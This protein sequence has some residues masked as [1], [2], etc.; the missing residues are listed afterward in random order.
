ML[1]KKQRERSWETSWETLV[2][3]GASWATF[4]C[5]VFHFWQVWSCS[6]NCLPCVYNL[7]PVKQSN[8]PGMYMFPKPLQ[9]KSS[10][11]ET[12]CQRRAVTDRFQ[13]IFPRI[14]YIFASYKTYIYFFLHG[15]HPIAFVA[16]LYTFKCWRRSSSNLTPRRL[17]C[18]TLG[19]SLQVCGNLT[20]RL[21]P[22]LTGT[23]L[24]PEASDRQTS[25]GED[26]PFVFLTWLQSKG[27]ALSSCVILCSVVGDN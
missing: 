19:A 3:E 9:C 4:E 13:P 5:N 6:P 11:C 8:A 10:G 15:Q 26:L 14:L 7:S 16:H 1:G 27:D 20:R 17:S 23:C 12:L 25:E 2:C 18:F 21:S 24:C 22:A